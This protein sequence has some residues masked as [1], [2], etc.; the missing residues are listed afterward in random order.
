MSIA[1]FNASINIG[2]GSKT[3]VYYCEGA[4]R[5]RISIVC[6]EDP[7]II[8][9][10]DYSIEP[11][12]EY[13]VA[14]KTLKDD[15]TPAI[16]LSQEKI[17]SDNIYGIYIPITGH[18]EQVIIGQESVLFSMNT[19]SGAGDRTIMVVKNKVVI[20]RLTYKQRQPNTYVAF[21]NNRWRSLGDKS[22][23]MAN[24]SDPLCLEVAT[25]MGWLA[26]EL[27]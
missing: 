11:N 13:R 20:K 5:P 19:S 24:L 16:I 25:Q 23:I 9:K 21:E 10:N 22:D 15:M 12:T 18:G 7:R 6:E 1:I 27:P 8:F 4:N 14:I 3:I 26:E 17:K 2:K